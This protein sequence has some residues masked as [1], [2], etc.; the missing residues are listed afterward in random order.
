MR[1]QLHR[2]R[3]QQY[4]LMKSSGP[5]SKASQCE[6]HPGPAWI[7]CRESRP[8]A[9]L[10]SRPGDPGLEQQLQPRLVIL[11]RRFHRNKDVLQLQALPARAAGRPQADPPRRPRAAADAPA[12]PSGPR[13]A[14]SL[15]GRAAP[16]G[17]RLP[18][19]DGSTGPGGRRAAAG[20]GGGLPAGQQQEED[21][22]GGDGQQEA[23]S[24]EPQAGAAHVAAPPPP[25]RLMAPGSPAAGFPRGLHRT[26]PGRGGAHGGQRPGAPGR[27]ASARSRPGARPDRTERSGERGRSPRAAGAPR[28]PGPSAPPLGASGEERRAAAPLRASPVGCGLAAPRDPEAK[29]GLD[30]GAGRSAGSGGR[31]GRMPLP[32]Q[33]FNLQVRGALS[34]RSGYRRS[35]AASFGVVSARRSAARSGPVSPRPPCGVRGL[36]PR[37][38]AVVPSRSRAAPLS[39]SVRCGRPLFR[40]DPPA[41]RGAAPTERPSAVCGVVG[42]AGR[43]EA[44]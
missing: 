14:A 23:G 33:V 34:R 9:H 16:R 3:T 25:A 20:R 26:A 22:G 27:A 11:P 43:A 35:V 18:L 36:S 42:G 13:A 39:R 7:S 4:V 6:L 12:A 32:V 10:S 2:E 17:P 28:G 8:G 21:G 44:P 1:K 41:S 24:A 19:R 5:F 29:T 15:P 40:R 37:P 31:E 38:S 30:V